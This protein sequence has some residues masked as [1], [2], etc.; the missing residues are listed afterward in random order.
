MAPDIWFSFLRSGNSG[1]LLGICDHNVRDILGLAVLFAA[2]AR[3]AGDPLGTWER[4]GVDLE[5]LALRWREAA[6]ASESAGSVFAGRVSPEGATAEK[7]L[8]T[9]AARGWPQA[10]YLWGKDLLQV[11]AAAGR[12]ELA[13]LAG[14]TLLPAGLRAAAYRTLAIDAEWRLDDRKAALGFTEAALK[15]E[16][17]GDRMRKNFLRRRERLYGPPERG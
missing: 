15:L 3:I 12:K 11:R 13:A 17:I 7:L 2:L 9:A 6:K 4:Y 8:E 14:E 1:P 16:G 10:R 5:S